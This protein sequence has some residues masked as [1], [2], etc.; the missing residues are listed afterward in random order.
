MNGTN[1]QD[2]VKAT[3][4]VTHMFEKLFKNLDES[5]DVLHTFMVSK[6][7]NNGFCCT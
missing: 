7:T 4:K 5:G 3:S 6:M 2:T 1:S